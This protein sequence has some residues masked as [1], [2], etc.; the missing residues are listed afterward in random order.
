MPFLDQL[1]QLDRALK[2]QGPFLV[3]L[4]LVLFAAMPSGTAIFAIVVPALPLIALYAFVVERPTFQDLV[5]GT[6]LGLSALLYLA[7]RE[8]VLL[9]AQPRFDQSLWLQ[10]IGFA[11]AAVTIGAVGWA[12]MS[13]WRGAVLD[14]TLPFLQAM[15]GIALYPWCARL[16]RALA[17]RPPVVV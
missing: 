14:P 1:V 9:Q 17:P 13:A 5:V 12:F 6:P 8:I 16:V 15:A 3:A 11:A 4:L 2:R 7:L 10:W